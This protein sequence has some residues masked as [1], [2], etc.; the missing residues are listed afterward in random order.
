M[1]IK[2]RYFG[3][4]FTHDKD[5]AF[6]LIDEIATNKGLGSA[7]QKLVGLSTATYLYEDGELRWIKPSSS[8]RG[9]RFNEVW[10]D[11]STPKE[12]IDCIIVPCLIGDNDSIHYF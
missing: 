1:S 3:C 5:K 8:A 11:F 10:I 6:N 9:M 4:I 2:R 12:I 7:F